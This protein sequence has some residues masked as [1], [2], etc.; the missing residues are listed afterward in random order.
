MSHTP[1]NRPSTTFL[2]ATNRAI[3]ERMARTRRP[4]L[5]GHWDHPYQQQL[6]ETVDNYVEI[7]G[8]E[9]RDLALDLHAHP[10]LAFEERRSASAVARVV[11]KHGFAVEHGV[12]DVATALRAEWSSPGFGAA[13]HPTIA[14]MSEYDALP[15]IGHACGHNL[16]AASGVGA[17]VSSVRALEAA[18]IDARVV[19][20]GT[21]A[22]EG[23]SG[24]EYMIRGGML[25]GVDVAV[26]MHPFS[27]DIASHAWVGRRTLNVTFSGISAHASS[28]PFMGRNALDAA[29]LAYQGIGLLRQQ[30]PPS[31]RLHAVI[32]EGG[33]RPSVIPDRARMDIYVRSLM[34]DT[35]LDLSARIDDILHGAALMAGVTVERVWDVHPMSLPI[36]NNQTLA[37]RWAVTQ[38]RRDRLALPAGVV[39][40]TLAASTDFGNVSHLV[41]AIHP[42]VK[43]APEGVAL[44]T[45]DF[46]TWARSDEGIRG[47]IDATAGLAQV[48]TDCA[49]DE[50][51]LLD[52]QQEFRDAGGERSVREMLAQES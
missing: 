21:P 24:K 7:L 46:A 22:E 47:L 6:W 17:F 33:N 39:P 32:A 23:H 28:Q 14:V 37:S 29:T 9:L 43:I 42:M 16:I 51:L 40:D 25:E 50:K 4:D 3:R 12:H 31:D 15:G 49:A 34:V 44:H 41:P 26:M 11:E 48:I 35:L 20:L 1:R 18:G 10:E 13:Q 36:R 45:E 8:P 38:A 5:D 30:M 52:A 27:F 19:F 2:D